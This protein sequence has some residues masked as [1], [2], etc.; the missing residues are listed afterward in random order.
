MKKTK[1][2]EIVYGAMM[3]A[4]YA[5]FMLF[6]RYSGGMLY[7]ALYY[8]LPLPFIVYG[9]K[10]G[11][12]MYGAM[13]FGAVVLGFMFGLAETAFFGLTAILVSYVIV[14]GIQNNWTGTKTMLLVML[15]TVGTQILSVTLFAALFGY[16]MA[17]ELQSIISMISEMTETLS[18]MGSGYSFYI[19]EQQIRVIFGFTTVLM[20]C[21]EA[22]LFTTLS[23]LILIRLKMARVPKFSLIN[24][25]FS[26][27]IGILFIVFYI[28]QMKMQNDFVLFGFLSFYM[29]ILAQG[30]SY[31]F[32]LNSVFT[33][34]PLL[35]S[36]AFIAC[37]IPLIN[38]FIAGMGLL[39][40]FSENRKKIMYNKYQRGE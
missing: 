4:L 21:L 18:M 30:V 19:S 29:M 35:N 13:M 11:T 17:A 3:L 28:L 14:R 22:Y 32:F 2:Q 40:I 39:D 36:L 23:D 31:C 37:F 34:K 24:L 8:F 20:G 7:M 15:L 5:L 6:D 27:L 26:K 38:Y 33:R 9:L 1:T 16:D 10:Y 25:R 12:K